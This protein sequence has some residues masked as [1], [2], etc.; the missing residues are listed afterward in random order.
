MRNTNRAVPKLTAFVMFGSLVCLTF[1]ADDLQAQQNLPYH[2]DN[3]IGS[4]TSTPVNSHSY[5][6]A[7]IFYS[8]DICLAI[9]SALTQISTNTDYKAKSVVD[10]R[11]IYAPSLTTPL[12]C[13]ASPWSTVAS[14]PTAVTI[15][16]PAATIAV[17]ATWVLPTNTQI[18]GVG[19]RQTML[20]AAASMTD[21]ID[22]GVLPPPPPAIPCLNDDCNGMAI[23]HLTL[24]GGSGNATNLIVNRGS[25]EQS[26]VDDVMLQGLSAAGTGTGLFIIGQD[27]AKLGYAVNSGPYSNISF[28]GSGTCVNI[29]GTYATRGIHGLTCVGS[30]SGSAVLLDGSNNSIEDVFLSSYA[31]GIVIGSQASLGTTGLYSQ[32][33]VLLNIRG[34]SSLTNAVVHICGPVGHSPCPANSTSYPAGIPGDLTIMGITNH[35]SSPNTIQDD[36]TNS[37]P[38]DTYIGMYV[39]GETVSGFSVSP[40][41]ATSTSR[42]TTSPSV[43]TWYVGSTP[44]TSGS[45]CQTGSLFSI[46]SGTSTPSLSLCAGGV[47][48]GFSSNH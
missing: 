33:N 11:G 34:D 21:L 14:P 42:F 45:S 29:Q 37:S 8:G 17:G 41:G 18:I 4:T 7:S 48:G 13:A 47:W 27:N 3:A 30:G 9:G 43:P 39:L 19:P 26:Y 10:A 28:V 16:L 22:M 46:I 12:T 38:A 44:P 6:D 23:R 20:Q 25:Q 5:V 40:T 36:V 24:D 2:A 15:L 35:S 32:N 1:L 31:D